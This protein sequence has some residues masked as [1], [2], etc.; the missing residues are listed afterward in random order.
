MKYYINKHGA[1]Y[2]IN[3]YNVEVFDLDD[4][5]NKNIDMS[6]MEEG[7]IKFSENRSCCVCDGRIRYMPY[8]PTY[9]NCDKCGNFF[10][11]QVFCYNKGCG[12]TCESNNN[13]TFCYNCSKGHTIRKEIVGGYL[14]SDKQCS[15]CF[16]E[17]NK[18]YMKD[19]VLEELK[20]L[21]E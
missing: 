4:P 18:E 14:V 10:C 9:D 7:H 11:L 21:K 20:E 19:C 16:L 13:C 6:C 8:D 5:V 3:K 17:F 15:D 12:Y 1:R 2:Y